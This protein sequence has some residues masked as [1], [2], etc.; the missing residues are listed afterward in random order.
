[1]PLFHI[2][3]FYRFKKAIAHLNMFIADQQV[4]DEA[5]GKK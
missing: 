5:D 3:D 4:F 2:Q 1:M